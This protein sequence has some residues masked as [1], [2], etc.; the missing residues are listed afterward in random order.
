M[1]FELYSIM[2]FCANLKKTYWCLNKT[3]MINTSRIGS[4][5]I[6]LLKSSRDR[7]LKPLKQIIVKIEQLVIDT[8]K[9]T[10]IPL[11]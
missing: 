5:W 10:K 2:T 1:P 9:P 11:F 6:T 8:V 4:P 7:N 3:H